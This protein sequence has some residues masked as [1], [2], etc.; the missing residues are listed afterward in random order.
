MRVEHPGELR[1]DWKWYEEASCP[2]LT[3]VAPALPPAP[4]LPHTTLLWRM[5][6]F[7]RA[8]CRPWCR[9]ASLH[10]QARNSKLQ[11]RRAAWDFCRSYSRRAVSV[12]PRPL[13]SSDCE[14]NG[15]GSDC[16]AAWHLL[17]TPTLPAPP[18]LSREAECFWGG[19]LFGTANKRPLTFIRLYYYKQDKIDSTNE[20]LCNLHIC[21]VAPLLQA[22]R[23]GAT[24][25]RGG[26]AGSFG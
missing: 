14:A 26:G 24:R 3:A 8:V 7:A 4:R 20:V 12:P 5:R 10:A 19:S 6:S 9:A 16:C 13:L 17:S 25:T 15:G 18:H 21:G 23:L 2:L 22:A 11:V 1:T